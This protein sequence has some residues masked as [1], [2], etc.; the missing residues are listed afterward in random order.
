MLRHLA[1]LLLTIVGCAVSAPRPSAAQDAD[2]GG[3]FINPFPAGDIYKVVIIGD[4]LAEGLAAGVAQAFQSDGRVA[5]QARPFMINGLM[6]QDFDEKLVQLEE[7][8]KTSAP[9][10]A[11]I[12]LGAWD[13]VTIRDASG[14]RLAVGSPTWRAEY[15]ARGD[16][17]MKAL[18]RRNVAAY[19]VGLPIVRRADANA[20]AQMMNDI[21]RERIYLN[22]MKYID[23]YAG[24]T[25]ENGSY[26]AYGPDITG[27]IRLLRQGDGVYFTMDGYRK[28]AHFVEQ[29]M[30]RDLTNAKELRNVPLEGDTDEQAKINPDKPKLAAPVTKDDAVSAKDRLTQ[31][32]TGDTKIPA[33]GEQ[34]ADNGKINLRIIDAGGREEVV[35]LDV[36]RPAIPASVIALVTRRESPDRL[37]QLGEP[38]LDQISGGLT[39][40]STVAL[41]TGPA[42]GGKRLAPSQAPYFRVLFKGERLTPKPGRADDLTWPRPAA[43]TEASYLPPPPD[44]VETGSTAATEPRPEEKPARRKRSSP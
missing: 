31:Q 18:K 33:D 2:T 42:T 21:M 7:D 9:H 1:I 11:L 23:A 4:D 28:L 12:M 37:S 22:G 16:R 20:D 34:K 13:R 40:M 3:A 10:V 8:L 32:A 43:P 15:G 39:V 38:I 27:K 5:I 17:L 36:V 41:A 6:R 19:W 24:F 44:P 25:D 30:R 14:K 26:S 29:E 35:S